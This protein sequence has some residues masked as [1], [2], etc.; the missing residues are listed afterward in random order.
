M[1]LHKESNEKSE[2]IE[3]DVN[4]S[5]E[6]PKY[7]NL[8]LNH[9]VLN[10]WHTGRPF[11]PTARVQAAPAVPPQLRRAEALGAAPHPQLQH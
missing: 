8:A 1:N 6:T 7:D 5:P 10:S 2:S 11:T 3:L 9:S 4:Y